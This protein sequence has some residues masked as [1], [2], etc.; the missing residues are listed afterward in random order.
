MQQSVL[1]EI[2]SNGCP[3]LAFSLL[4]C[5]DCQ[6][7]PGR[8][9]G[10]ELASAGAVPRHRERRGTLHST[11]HYGKSRL[12]MFLKRESVVVSPYM[13]GNHLTKRSSRQIAA[14]LLRTALHDD[15][16]GPVHLHHPCHYSP[17][18]LFERR[19]KENYYTPH[20]MMIASGLYTSITLAITSSNMLSYATVFKTVFRER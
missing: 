19:A 9:Q 17:K 15:C 6:D 16:L 14:A 13:P 10:L 20:C 4:S 2:P 18:N 3:D 12:S 5:R 8:H 1:T 11:H 7:K